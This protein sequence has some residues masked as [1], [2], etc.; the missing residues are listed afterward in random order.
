MRTPSMAIRAAGVGAKV[1]EEVQRQRSAKDGKIKAQALD[2]ARQLSGIQLEIF[3]EVG[4]EERLFGS[5][6]SA[7][8]AEKLAEEGFEIDKRKIQLEEPIKQL[9][10]YA[11]PVKLFKDV[12]GTVSLKVE[13]K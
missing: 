3:V 1:F 10:Q 2:L 11:V 12:D 5:V 8:I 4:E 6:T 13:K 9:G 7:D